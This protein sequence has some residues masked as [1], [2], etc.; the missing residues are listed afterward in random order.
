M[1]EILP[2]IGMR[3]NSQLIGNLSKVLSP[4]YDVI[5]PEMQEEL[6]QRHPNN[7]VRMELSKAEKEDDGFS[8]KYT[9]AANTLGTWRSDGILIEDER[10]SFYLYE[11]QFKT[12]DGETR[13]RRGFFALVK[14]EDAKTGVIRGHADTM[15]GPKK[16]R[17]KLLRAT[18]A[19]FS[20]IFVLYNDPKEEVQGLLSQRM[21]EKPWEEVTDEDGVTH[22]LWVVQKKDFLIQ[23]R[24]MLKSR[25]LYI[26]DG[27]HRYET[28]LKFRDEQREETGKKDGKQPFDYVMM[29]LTNA[30]QDGLIVQANHRALSRSF[31]NQVDMRDAMDELKENFDFAKDKADLDKPAEEA[32]RITAKLKSLGAKAHAFAMVLP[33]GTVY[34]LTLK[35][36][37]DPVELI[38]DEQVDDKVKGLDVCILHSHIINYVMAGNPEFEL[39]DDECFY[40]PDAARVLQMLKQKKAALG[41]LLNPIPLEQVMKT[42]GAGL[43]LPQKSTYFHPKVIT[44][45]VIRNMECEQKKAPKR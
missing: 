35:K 18:N 17:L 45:L 19:N 29:F 32:K 34:Y 21:T 31:V 43:R 13:K 7:V 42:V 23:L 2:F 25:K 28:A 12:P 10:H 5:S 9:R 27:H 6:H 3:Y 40:Q 22:R 36:D 1:A 30:E 41:F 24:D 4:P 8:N 44:G 26:A 20:P 15:E 38:D 16:D 39:D 37:V 33:D 14:L 11:Q